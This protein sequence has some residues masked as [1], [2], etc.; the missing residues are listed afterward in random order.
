MSI[1]DVPEI[2]ELFK[3]FCI[4]EVPT[5]YLTAGA[6]KQKKVTELLISNYTPPSN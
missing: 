1:N 2:R 5:T 4:E 6:N 3:D